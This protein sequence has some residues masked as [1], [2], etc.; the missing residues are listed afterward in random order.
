MRSRAAGISV[1]TLISIWCR[2][3]LRMRVDVPSDPALSQAVCQLAWLQRARFSPRPVNVRFV[4]GREGDRDKFLYKR[5]GFTPS[6]SFRQWFIPVC[7]HLPATVHNLS[8]G[9]HSA[10]ALM[11]WLLLNLAQEQLRFSSVPWHC[12]VTCDSWWNNLG[13]KFLIH[14]RLV[15][16]SCMY[17]WYRALVCMLDFRLSPACQ[18]FPHLQCYLEFVGSYGRFGIT[19]RSH[20]QGSSSCLTLEDNT[21]CFFPKRRW[22]PTNIRCVTS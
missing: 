5:F 10:F 21:V 1:S 20:L 16:S 11:A 19:C 13:P 2:R 17:A 7:I 9:Q 22:L 4:W 6:T 14:D 12:D 18:I 15:Q 8:D 3:R